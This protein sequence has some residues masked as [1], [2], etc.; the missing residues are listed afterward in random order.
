VHGKEKESQKR[1]S[2]NTCVIVALFAQ[3]M[4]CQPI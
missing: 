4:V 2:K 3:T 1:A